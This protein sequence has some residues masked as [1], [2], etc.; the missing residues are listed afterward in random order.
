MRSVLSFTLHAVG[1]PLAALLR[2][3]LLPLM[4]VLV[5]AGLGAYASDDML[6]AAVCAVLAGVCHEARWRLLAV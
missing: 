1:W 3:V 5:V 6:G 2:L 4:V